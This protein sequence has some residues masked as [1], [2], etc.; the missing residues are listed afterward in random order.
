VPAP[1]TGS[2]ER[3]GET[4]AALD[5]PVARRRML[6]IVNPYATTVSD[7]LRNL[8]VHALQSRYDVTA[9]DTQRRGHA[10][11]LVR[12]GAREGYE[13][14]VAFGGDGTVNEAANGLTGT[15]VPLTHLPGGA[16]NVFGKMLGIPG[17]I[18][19]ATEHLL[20]IADDWRPRKVDLATANGHHFTFSAGYGL[21]ASVVKAVDS[22]PERKHRYGEWYFTS[23]AIRTFVTRY[24]VRPPHVAVDAGGRTLHGITAVVQNGDPFTYFNRR[25]I[26]LAENVSVDSGDLAG[27]V[28]HRA[29]PLAVPSVMARLLST[30]LRAGDSRAISLF[31]GAQAVRAWSVDG[32]PVPLEL[33]GDWIGD[34]TEV[35]FR[36]LPG[37]LT[38]VA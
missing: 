2:L 26:R 11:E 25:P 12:E 13:V 32:R 14:V 7:R 16:T 1:P 38:V 29:S 22:H 19:D 34:S 9:F 33:D 8:V 24:V 36:V 30:R 35:E 3:L 20:R 28:L 37:A 18:V 4:F 31:D 6:V 21:D 5:Q 15:D 17:E 27:A 23:T 10:T